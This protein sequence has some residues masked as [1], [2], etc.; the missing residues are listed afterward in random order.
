MGGEGGRHTTAHFG[1][2]KVMQNQLFRV[3]EGRGNLM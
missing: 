3:L 1:E 2:S